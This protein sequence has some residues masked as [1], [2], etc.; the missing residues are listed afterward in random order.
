M[1]D[2]GVRLNLKDISTQFISV[3]VAM[4]AL[5]ESICEMANK[6]VSETSTSMSL[7]G[8][9]TTLEIL[10]LTVVPVRLSSSAQHTISRQHGPNQGMTDEVSPIS[11]GFLT[12]NTIQTIELF[13]AWYGKPFL[14]SSV[15]DV[16]RRISIE[17]VSIEVDPTKTSQPTWD[18]EKNVDA[19]VHWCKELWDSIYRVRS[20]CPPEMRRLFEHIR[21]LVE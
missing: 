6:E 15:G 10:F 3:A 18:L 1:N 9:P 20:E 12:V 7:L 14:E 19:L 16:I 2:L 13:M 4:D 5:V 17:R 21:K 11:S 8:L